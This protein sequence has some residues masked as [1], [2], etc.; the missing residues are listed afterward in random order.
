M[1]ED[2]LISDERWNQETLDSEKE[3][4]VSKV[5]MLTSAKNDTIQK[6]LQKTIQRYLQ[7]DTP[8]STG[9]SRQKQQRSPACEKDTGLNATQKTAPRAVRGNP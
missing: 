7:N 2:E 5:R 9:I 3:I 4:R 6:D 1:V 8:I